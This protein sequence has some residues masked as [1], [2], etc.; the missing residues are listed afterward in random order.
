MQL[1][2]DTGLGRNGAFHQ[3][4]GGAARSDWETLVDAAARARAGGSVEV[5]G[6]FT[7]FAYADAPHHP[8]VRAQQEAFTEA[9]RV[10]EAAGLRD[11]LRHM[12][13]SAAVLT[14]PESAWDMVRPGVAVY[15]LSPVPE[16]GSSADFGLV[17]AMTATARVALVKEVPQGQGVSYGHTYTTPAP[18]RLAD[19]PLGYADG[20]PRHASNRAEVLVGGARRRIAGRV[21][22]DQFVVDVGDLPVAAGD[23][24]LLFGPGTHGEP[25]AQD[26]AEACGTIN[27]EIVTRFGARVP[28]VHLGQ[29]EVRA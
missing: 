9:V 2:V 18:T 11:L 7:H 16:L 6:I 25:T 23:E 5:T 24:V 19:V 10:A 21:C 3:R 26:W 27:Y 28:R 13:N 12:A 20:V 22:M 1:K 4:V 14:S 17:P 15:G 29:A 8:T